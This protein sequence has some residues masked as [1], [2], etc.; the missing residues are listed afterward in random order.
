M[1]AF[2]YLSVPDDKHS[3]TQYIKQEREKE[4][5]TEREKKEDE[6]TKK[7]TKTDEKKKNN[8]KESHEKEKERQKKKLDTF[9]TVVDKASRECPQSKGVTH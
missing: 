1:S 9:L 3:N 2:F 7:E 5:K 8:N 6:K 4:G